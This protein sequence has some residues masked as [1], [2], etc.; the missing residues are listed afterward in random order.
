MLL[1]VCIFRRIVFSCNK[2]ITVCHKNL[3]R[4][5]NR[6]ITVMATG[7]VIKCHVFRN[8]LWEKFGR[9]ELYLIAELRVCQITITI[10]QRKS[11]LENINLYWEGFKEARNYLLKS[12]RISL[13]NLIF[14]PIFMSLEIIRLNT[15]HW[16]LN[17]L[18]V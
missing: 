14:Y 15:I 1:R 7:S 11:S 12:I 13:Q 18:L 16:P 3:N 6:W 2:L 5:R 9:F 4:G 17:N 8:Y 10:A